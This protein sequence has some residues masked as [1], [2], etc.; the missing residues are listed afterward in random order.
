MG[1]ARLPYSCRYLGAE[2]LAR[3]LQLCNETSPSHVMATGMNEALKI[4]T[5]WSTRFLLAL[6]PRHVGDLD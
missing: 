4:T 1:A 5:L 2:L 3:L 6:V